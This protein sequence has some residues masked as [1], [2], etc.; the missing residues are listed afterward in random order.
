[1]NIKTHTILKR[2]RIPMILILLVQAGLYFG[3]VYF[4]GTI[5]QLDSNAFDI[6]N[7]R[8]INRK[9]YLK[10]EMIQRWSNLSDTEQAVRTQVE[11]DLAEAN[12]THADITANSELAT[13]ILKNTAESIVYLLRRQS[14]TGAFLILSG[15]DDGS[16]QPGM[17]VQR[18]GLYVRDLDPEYNAE[19]RSDLLLERAPSSV[20]RQLGIT[21]DTWW[22]P[23]FVFHS[24]DPQQDYAY[25]Y[26]P[27]CAAFEHTDVGYKDLGY[28][29]R[30]FR[31]SGND[32]RVI[33]YSVPLLAADGKPYGV[34]GVEISVDYL[35]RQLPFNEL[36]A[37]KQ[38]TY[39]LGVSAADGRYD[40][41]MA[42]GPAYTKLFGEQE[43]IQ[44]HSATYNN[45]YELVKSQR[46]QGVSYGCVQY[47]TLYNTNTPFEQERWA[48][49]GI[50]EKDVLLGFS[51]RVETGIL[52]ALILSLTIGIFSVLFISLKVTKP[53]TALV[54]QV[55]QSNPR[56][57]VRF[58][59]IRIA[60]IDELSAAIEHLSVDVADAAS[61]LSQ[62]VEMTSTA[63]GAFEYQPDVRRYF[64]TKRF[65]EILG[66]E[67]TYA[68][69]G[70]MDKETFEGR[71]HALESFLDDSGPDDSV[72]IYKLYRRPGTPN[73]VRVKTVQDGERRLGVA[74][75]VTQEIIEKR[76]MA[77][78]RDY[79]LLTSLLNRRAF[80]ATMNTLFEKPEELRIAAMIMFDLDNLKYINDNYGH[81]YGDQYIRCAASILRKYTPI[82]TVLSR[83]S[84]D[85]FYVFIYGFE[86]EAELRDIIGNIREGIRSTVFP[87]PDN[88]NFRV[89]ISGGIAWYPKD[90]LVYEQLIRY[91]DFAMYTVKNTEKGHIEEFSLEEYEK[92]SYLLHNKEELNRFI[93][94]EL[95]IYHF[96]PIV[97]VRTGTVFA[98]EALMRSL[99]PA[100][101]TPLEILKLAHSQSK[102]Y[103]IERLTWF[104]SLGDFAKNPQVGTDCRLFINSIA[105]QI[106]S[107]K[108]L[109]AFEAQYRP[110][111]HR[112]VIE[113]TEEDKINEGYLARKQARVRDWQGAMALDDFGNGY[114]G[115]AL[116]L[117]MSPDYVKIDMAIVRNI[118]ADENRQKLLDN[119]ISY[120][121]ERH[122]PVIAEGVETYE[123][124]ETL[125]RSGVDYLQGYYI[126]M[127][128]EVP[129]L[130]DDKVVQEIRT[131]YMRYHAD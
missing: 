122:M 35:L 62:I 107:E 14:V 74:E 85:E 81:D 67:D 51:R 82:H 10:N 89:R 114:N 52:L 29:S 125:I 97:D 75:D 45:S 78:E 23:Q 17:E 42:S 79:D 124:M 15:P 34:L 60:E 25:Y 121:R 71:L 130:P 27:L 56:L 12:A 91:A 8:V 99:L 28:W 72:R 116:L 5:R 128:H 115:E 65:F 44:L 59:P 110:F 6:L 61:K 24:A 37:D 88:S 94:E 30:P 109:A 64:Y 119:L 47:L 68:D 13:H 63:I 66:V 77:Y 41:V 93:D 22:R 38:G 95:L 32:I 21:M 129:Q 36:A 118:N 4:G 86:S 20:A 126:G 58:Q 76:K 83:M 117:Y 31:L 1:M 39:F 57:P 96:Q 48:L 9:N 80:H 40:K 90:S 108:D 49:V 26:K 113:L 87:L 55:K 102:L 43:Y 53:I 3:T 50:V 105:S 101:K 54:R 100:L 33:T 106:L 11:Q 104:H 16:L 19:D 112:I 127:P 103:E 111:L 92:D 98:Y 123:E 69:G 131:L 46:W 70:S 7:E 2:I 84:G 73:W 120:T 18:S